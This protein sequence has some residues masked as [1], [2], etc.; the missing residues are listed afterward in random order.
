MKEPSDNKLEKQLASWANLRA[1]QPER[2]EPLVD[3][4]RSDWSNQSKIVPTTVTAFER[5][6]SNNRRLAWV[7]ATAATAAALWLAFVISH[8]NDSAFTELSWNEHTRQQTELLSRCHELFGEQL[9]WMV[10]SGD[11]NDLGLTFNTKPTNSY[12]AIRL[13]LTARTMGS[14]EWR[15]V[16]T[17]N[18]IAAGESYVHF[19]A[20]DADATQLSLW[21]YPLDNRVISIDLQYQPKNL[22]ETLIEASVAQVGNESQT[23]SNFEK[24]GVE[25]RLYQTAELI[26]MAGS[27]GRPS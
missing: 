25:Y 14:D 7:A 19:P 13:R 24:N 4:I 10:E 6:N 11:R 1:S 23:V 5:P 22:P 16:Q 20:N 15:V 8:Q 12:V 26:S 3:R 9:A 21:A 18:V 17:L 2:L 27:Q